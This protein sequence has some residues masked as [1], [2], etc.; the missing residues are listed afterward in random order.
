MEASGIIHCSKR[1]YTCVCVYV[2]MGVLC[3]NVQWCA[4]R[5]G[6]HKHVNICGL[7]GLCDVVIG[8]QNVAYMCYSSS[9]FC[10]TLC[11]C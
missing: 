7:L 6:A 2:C 9:L 5:D 8:T 1:V 10:F 3:V 4:L 11:R